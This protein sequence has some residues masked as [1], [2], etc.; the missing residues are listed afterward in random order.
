MESPGPELLSSDALISTLY[1]SIQALGR[2]FDVTADIRLL[3]C[4]GAPGSRLV[5]VDEDGTHDLRVEGL[6]LPNVSVDIDCSS[7]QKGSVE[8]TSVLSFLEVFPPDSLLEL[9][10]F[11]LCRSF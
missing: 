2:G 11:R 7:P 6:L 8:N 1:N 10:I 4:K 9:L 5:H 3:Y